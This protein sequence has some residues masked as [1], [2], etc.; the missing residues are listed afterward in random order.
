MT[1]HKNHLQTECPL[2]EIECEFHYAGCDVKSLRRNIMPDYLKESL[3]THFLLIAMSHEQ[4]QDEVKALRKA[5]QEETKALTEEIKA[6][7]EEIN[8]L[9][10]QRRQLR[11]N[12][13]L[14]PVDF[15]V[16]TLAHTGNVI[17]GYRHPSTPIAKD[18][19]YA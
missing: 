19:N 2:A 3:I 14:Y 9:K 12:M 1:N 15:V 8:V 11:V 16:K 5:H 10:R 7:Y 17:H 13:Q 18:T 4:Q 6:L